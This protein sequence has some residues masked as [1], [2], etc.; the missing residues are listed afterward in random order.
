MS[1]EIL[2]HNSQQVLL[3]CRILAYS[4]E[5]SISEVGTASL[6]D[7]SDRGTSQGQLSFLS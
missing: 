1:F 4:Y 7:H 6:A 2:H 5:Y 3:F